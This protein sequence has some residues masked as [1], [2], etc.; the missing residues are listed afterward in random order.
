MVRQNKILVLILIFLALQFLI[1]SR[2]QAE[3]RAFLLGVTYD[4]T[5]GEQQVLT[6]LDNIQYESYYKITS[7]QKTRIID[8]WMCR[9]RTGDFT[10]YCNKPVQSPVSQS[11]AN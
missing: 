4:A 7:T 1:L 9:E 2:A 10:P 11:K 3:Y 6:N 5:S 8:H